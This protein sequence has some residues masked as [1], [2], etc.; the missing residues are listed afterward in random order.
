MRAGEPATA[1]AYEVGQVTSS[2]V[3]LWVMHIDN[4][5]SEFKSRFPITAHKYNVD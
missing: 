5:R 2:G 1:A 4:S 3:Y